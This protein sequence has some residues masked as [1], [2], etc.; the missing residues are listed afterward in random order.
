MV[1]MKILVKSY[2]KEDF[3]INLEA[4]ANIRQLRDKL[5]AEFKQD[6]EMI[7]IAS[8]KDTNDRNFGP[9]YSDDSSDVSIVD[10]VRR[11]AAD[12]NLVVNNLTICCRLALGAGLY[13]PTQFNPTIHS[14]GAGLVDNPENKFLKE[15]LTQT[16]PKSYNQRLMDI[17]FDMESIPEKFIDQITNIIMNDPIITSSQRIFDRSTIV[18][19]NYVDPNSRQHVTISRPNL[20]LRAEIEQFVRDAEDLHRRTEERNRRSAERKNVADNNAS[21]AATGVSQPQASNGSSTVNGLSSSPAIALQSNAH[22]NA[23][24]GV[25]FSGGPSG[26]PSHANNQQTSAGA[27]S[28][29]ADVVN[30]DD[31]PD[32][33]PATRS[34]L[35]TNGGKTS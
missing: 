28:T 8:V 27:S 30:I 21:P 12:V 35:P 5:A 9:I 24:N 3:S 13:R 26:T 15:V 14:A 2:M 33:A 6:W 31:L 11:E 20:Q 34:G 1:P 18:R 22:G 29:H 4:N 25:Y 32:A 10:H 16:Q 19:L 17:K 23:V 7:E